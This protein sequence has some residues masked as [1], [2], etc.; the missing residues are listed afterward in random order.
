MRG[1][2]LI[3]GPALWL[4]L[5]TGLGAQTESPF[6]S[7][8]IFIYPEYDHPGVGIFVEGSIKPGEY[9]RFLEMQVPLETTMALSRKE[10][11]GEDASER[12]EIQIR[13]GQAFLP[14][15]LTEPQFQIQ[16][17]FNPF[18]AEGSDRSFTFD[19]V[20]N[21]ILPE[22]HLVLQQPAKAED[23]RHSLESAEVL[24]GDFG[25]KFYRQHID[26]LAPGTPYSVQI[27]YRNPGGE[28]TMNVVQASMRQQ[29]AEGHPDPLAP[30]NPRTRLPLV[31]AV[32]LLMGA[33]IFAGLKFRGQRTGAET[34]PAAS[35]EQTQAATHKHKPKGMTKFC[36]G[37][38]ILLR[39]GAK[40]CPS[41]GK[42]V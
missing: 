3:W 16:Y 38:G 34:G 30:V 12:I 32:V 17:Y 27:S 35:P 37:C 28:L 15:D 36:A 29:Q 23:F 42:A 21:E 22:W 40:F 26:G 6:N 10:V 19:I 20:M 39:P 33:A 13:E 18:A 25:L 24:D 11:E 7:F 41:C 9:P 4:L 31:A 2:K 14:L 5:A 8:D 1:I